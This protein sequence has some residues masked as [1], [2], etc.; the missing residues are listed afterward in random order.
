MVRKVNVYG[1]DGSVRTN[2]EI[3]ECFDEVV[4]E[5]LIQR[6]VNASEANKKQPQGRDPL[7]GQRN[8][9][10]TWGSGYGAARTPRLK[11]SGYPG[12]RSG[13]FAPNTVGGRTAHA[14]RA[15]KNTKKK[16]NKKE[17]RKALRSAIAA[18]GIK[19]YVENR[20]HVITNVLEFPMIVDDKLETMKYARQVKEVFEALG[21]TADIEKAKNK[22]KIRPGKGKRRGRKYKRKKG[23]LIVVSNNGGIYKAARNFAGLDVVNVKS[24]SVSDLAP[25][26]H[27]GRLTI[28][29]QAALKELRRL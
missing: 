13:A 27:P 20:G 8:T 2:V 26:T 17:R 25:G 4:R 5:D 12:A 23:P 28:W 9:A 22:R 7:A 11:G 10:E 24:L 21:I 16:I 18:T 15:E 19:E 14:P 29:T 1:L 3:P 6:A